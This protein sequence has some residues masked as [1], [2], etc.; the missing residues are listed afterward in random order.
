MF[1]GRYQTT[2]LVQLV[3]TLDFYEECRQRV[4]TTD[5]LIIDEISMVSCHLFDQVEAVCRSLRDPNLAFGGLQLIVAGDFL[6]LQPVPSPFIPGNCHIFAIVYMFHH[7]VYFLPS[8][9]IA[10]GCSSFFPKSCL[11]GGRAGSGEPYS[12]VSNKFTNTNGCSMLIF[13]TLIGQF[14]LVSLLCI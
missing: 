5:V 8:A 12:F 13:C 6:Q 9:S 7:V 10:K 1:D 4:K 3:A 14:G 2:T 11:S